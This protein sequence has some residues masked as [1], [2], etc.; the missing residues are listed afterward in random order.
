MIRA[1]VTL[2]D[3]LEKGTDVFH[4]PSGAACLPLALIIITFTHVA[5]LFISA[6]RPGHY[7]SRFTDVKLICREVKHGAQ[8]G[9]AS[10]LRFKLGS[11]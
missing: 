2:P 8:G 4:V 10:E 9:T 6:T 1:F 7:Y 11:A 5:Y 3:T